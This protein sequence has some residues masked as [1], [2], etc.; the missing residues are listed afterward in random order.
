MEMKTWNSMEERKIISQSTDSKNLKSKCT[1]FSGDPHLTY[2][3]G[4][5]PFWVSSLVSLRVFPTSPNPIPPSH[6]RSQ[7]PQRE[8]SFHVFSWSDFNI[9]TLDTA[10]VLRCPQSSVSVACY[11][12][13]GCTC[14]VL[15]NVGA[16]WV[17]HLALLRS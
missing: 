3:Q 6:T 14:D 5:T 17:E 11:T 16:I 13:H 7:A 1:D 4:I 9:Y 15:S 10:I 2:S 8:S 12:A